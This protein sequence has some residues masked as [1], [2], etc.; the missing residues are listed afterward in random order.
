MFREKK[1]S[2]LAGTGASPRATGFTLVELLVIVAIIVVLLALLIPGMDAAVYQAELATC[3]ARLKAGATGLATYA[4]ENKRYYP[5][6]S[7]ANN[8]TLSW[9]PDLL[10]SNSIDDRPR[11]FQA[12]RPKLLLD[13][14]SGKI[15]LEAEIEGQSNIG[16][17]YSLWFGWRYLTGS[18]KGMYKV[19]DRFTWMGDGYRVLISD[20]DRLFSSSDQST[21]PDRIGVMKFEGPHQNA[22]NPFPGWNLYGLFVTY[23]KWTTNGMG[24][25][26]VRGPL[27]LNYAYDDGAVLRFDRVGF[28]DERMGYIPDF[29]TKNVADSSFCRQMA[30]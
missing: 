6:R 20:E 11:I 22:P 19:G 7:G 3:S 4:F 23:S 15:D 17:N 28:E 24:G 14:F 10:T 26:R 16:S 27:D 25:A 8:T 1:E 18:E 13:P 2:R 12:I 5:F 9:Y 29:A 21:H 30:R